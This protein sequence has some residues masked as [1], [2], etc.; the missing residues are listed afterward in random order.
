MK[1]LIALMLVAFSVP[2]LASADLARSKNCLACHAADRKL[3]GPSFRD[4]AGRY[5]ER[6]IPH[7]VG[8]IQ[9]GGN[10]RWGP[11]PMP[12]NAAITKEEAEALARWVL[13]QK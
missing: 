5:S 3:V 9:R 6:D 4:V 11:I 7:M 10:G 8:V 1:Y 2:V 13:E 12:A